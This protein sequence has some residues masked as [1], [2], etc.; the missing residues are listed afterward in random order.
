M[1]CIPRLIQK[2]M[3]QKLKPNSSR[4]LIDNNKYENYTSIKLFNGNTFFNHKNSNIKI[5]YTNLIQDKIYILT[6]FYLETELMGRYIPS[7][8]IVTRRVHAI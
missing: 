7:K 8:R 3:F 4:T 1:N 6:K 2:P 5:L